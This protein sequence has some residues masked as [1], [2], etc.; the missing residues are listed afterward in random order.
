VNLL[1]LQVNETADRFLHQEACIPRQ[2][3]ALLTPGQV[4]QFFVG[5]SVGIQD[6]ESGDAKPLGEFSKH[7]VCHK[8]G[9]FRERLEKR[10]LPYPTFPKL[11]CFFPRIEVPHIET[12]DRSRPEYS[13][14]ATIP[15]SFQVIIIP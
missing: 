9:S 7:D 6:I 12:S 14:P 15:E 4:H 1:A 3:N 5:V 2:E 13:I 11:R 10:F 8:P